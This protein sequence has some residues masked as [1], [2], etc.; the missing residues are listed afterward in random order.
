MINLQSNYPVLAEQEQAWKALLTEAVERFGGESLRLPPFGGGS[1][2]RAQAAAW[3]K[4]DAERTFICESGHH[5]TLAALMAAKLHGKTIAVEELSYPWFMQ[6]ARMLGMKVAPVAMDRE[7]MLP[8]A[9]REACRRERISALYTMPSMHNPTGAVATLQRRQQIAEIAR[10]FD[11]TII[12]D[13]AYG[14]LLD[15]EP[16]HYSEV[17]PE[18]SFYIESLSKRV[19]PG[20][21]TGF[22]VCPPRLADDTELALRV[23]S[24]GSSTLLASLGC[25]MAADGRLQRAI[26]A[27]RKEGARRSSIAREMLAGFDVQGKGNTWHLW[28]QRLASDTR[29]DEEFERACQERGVLITGAR[30]FTAEGV[31]VPHAVRVGLGGETAAE[32]VREGL[33][34]LAEELRG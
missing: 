5:G 16:P 10:E 9:L 3:L 6:Q 4:T 29:T 32:R 33:T 31:P 11:L 30:W 20:L 25:V 8:E 23:I 21:R 7:C 1:H 14:F 2:L 19:A 22:A 12:D 17:A 13:G 24:S 28:V 18:R 15:D 34:I 27:K 26:Q